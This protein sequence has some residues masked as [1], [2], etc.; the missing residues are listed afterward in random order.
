[1]LAGISRARLLELLPTARYRVVELMPDGL[2]VLDHEMRIVDWN[3][4]ALRYGESPGFDH[5]GPIADHSPMV[6]VV[7]FPSLTRSRDASVTEATG[8][9]RDTSISRSPL[10]HPTRQTAG[11]R[12]STMRPRCARRSGGF[13]RRIRGSSSSIA[14]S[15]EA[16]HDGLT[17]L[18]NR[19]S[20]RLAR[21]RARAGRPRATSRW[22]ADPRCR[23]LQEDQR[24]ARARCG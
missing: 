3:P 13:R 24:P 21:T 9:L 15:C 12:S 23:S 6:A 2:I 14:S 22:T 8:S 1:M 4:A 5:G 7:P 20:R 19:V 10:D 17:G 11:S 18:F 16:I